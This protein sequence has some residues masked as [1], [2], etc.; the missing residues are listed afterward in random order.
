MEATE[1]EKHAIHGY[2][3]AASTAED[4]EYGYVFDQCTLTSDCPRKSVYLGRPWRNFA[5]TV[6]LNCELGEH[7]RDEG[8]DDWNKPEAHKT[9]FYA[10]YN[11]A[12]P[13]AAGL[14]DE[15]R[16]SFA[17]RLTERESLRFSKERVLGGSDGWCP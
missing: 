12:G 11:S 2:I 8:W 16:A 4:Q 3:T 5:K 15:R 6:F 9:V 14:H 7:V 17:K 10:E 1:G 13:G